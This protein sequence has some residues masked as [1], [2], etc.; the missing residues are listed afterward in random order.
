QQF[1]FVDFGAQPLQVMAATWRSAFRH[2]AALET[3]PGEMILLGTNSKAG[4]AADDLTEKMQAPHVRRTLAW[5]GWDWSMPL[6]LPAYGDDALGRIA[7]PVRQG[8]NT[9]AAGTL[10]LTLPLE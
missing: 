7:E 10:A 1:Q 5:I 3:A 9:V 6:N 2:V 4:L 8:G